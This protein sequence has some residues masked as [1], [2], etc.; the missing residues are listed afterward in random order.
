MQSIDTSY[1][2]RGAKLE[3][4]YE[5]AN[6]ENRK[7][8]VP[9]KQIAYN[10]DGSVKEITINKFDKD[11]VLIGS[12]IQDKMVKLLRLM[13]LQRLMVI[14][15]PHIKKDVGTVIYWQD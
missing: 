8:L 6:L 15:I 10:K 12:E 7:G 5:G 4:H 2:K 3:E 1:Y 14:L 9:S 13:T 11:G